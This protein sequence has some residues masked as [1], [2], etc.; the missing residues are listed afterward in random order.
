[1][2]KTGTEV[3]ESLTA[4]LVTYDQGNDEYV[5]Y[6]VEDGPWPHDEAEWRARLSGIQG[7]I[8]S[9]ADVAIDGHLAEKYPDSRGR[10]VRIQVDSPAGSPNQLEDLVGAVERFLREDPAYSEAI[11]NSGQI[12]GLRVVTGKQ[13]GRFK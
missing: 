12:Q 7:R 11:K 13:L 1:L 6:L 8:L 2:K 9:A 4:D 3:S 10:K 5:L